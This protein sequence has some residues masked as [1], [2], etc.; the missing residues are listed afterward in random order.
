M[1][2]SLTPW[3]HTHVSDPYDVE[4]D[5]TDIPIGGKL[6]QAKLELTATDQMIFQSDDDFKRAI[7]QK[8][9]SE[10]ARAMI[11]SNSIEFTRLPQ[12]GSGN[13]I[14]YARCYLAPDNQV[15]LLRTHYVD[16]K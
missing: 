6:I 9:A 10:L 5:F 15:K 4:F 7:K 16:K 3:H 12:T 14:I 13:D 2:I 1:A 11:E 8:I